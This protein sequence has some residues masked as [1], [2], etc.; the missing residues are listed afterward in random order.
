MSLVLTFADGTEKVYDDTEVEAVEI[1]DDTNTVTVTTTHGTDTYKDMVLAIG[2]RADEPVPVAN[3]LITEA[4]G[5][6]ESLY[7]KFRLA[8][9]AKSYNAY[10][11]SDGEADYHKVDGQLVRDYG[12]YGRVDVVGLRAGTYS[13]KVVPVYED[14]SE[15][16]ASTAEG[17]K[18]VPY[19][20]DG[21]AHHG[22]SEGIGAYNN[23]GTLKA[24]AKVV[25]ITKENA[26]ELQPLLTSYSKGT[27]ASTPLCVRVIGLLKKEDMGTLGSSAEGLQVKG[28]SGY[29]TLN[30][31][32][33]KSVV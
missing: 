28:N 1:D 11:K 25:Y 8:E 21:F 23:D 9:G 3:N 30:I 20:R 5:W 12:T 13:L 33:R 2:T 10:V 19:N 7:A 17:L 26:A 32:D 15:G 22:R 4:R 14:D 6:H 31:T 29:T 24:N 18:V 27:L 16:D